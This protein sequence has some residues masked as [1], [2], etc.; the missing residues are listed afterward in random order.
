[1]LTAVILDEWAVEKIKSAPDLRQKIIVLEAVT[2]IDLTT[3]NVAWREKAG[4]AWLKVRA[5]CAVRCLSCEQIFASIQDW[6][7]HRGNH[8]CEARG[9]EPANLSLTAWGKVVT[10]QEPRR[11]FEE[12]LTGEDWNWLLSWHIK[13]LEIET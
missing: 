3:I 6:C 12:L 1:L 11:S 13:G 7:E 2:G 9:H 4:R 10:Y 5:V 8:E